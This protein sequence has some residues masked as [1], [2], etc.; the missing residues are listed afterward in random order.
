MAPVGE[1]LLSGPDAG[2]FI[3]TSDFWLLTSHFLS[4]SA[5]SSLAAASS[6]ESLPV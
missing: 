2:G 5:S 1:A 6:W 3:L 4:I